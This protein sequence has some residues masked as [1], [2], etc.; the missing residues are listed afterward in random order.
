[1]AFLEWD[2]QYVNVHR[3]QFPNISPSHPPTLP[4][5]RGKSKYLET[6]VVFFRC[7][8][9]IVP[10][11][12]H[13]CIFSPIGHELV[14]KRISLN[15]LPR[16]VPWCKENMVTETS[17]KSEPWRCWNAL[18]KTMKFTEHKDWLAGTP[19]TRKNQRVFAVNYVWWVPKLHFT[20]LGNVI[21]S[22]FEEWSKSQFMEY[23]LCVGHS[24]SL[25]CCRW[26]IV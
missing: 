4:V 23:Q 12:L 19:E 7:S 20:C 14:R 18:H 22:T 13:P 16:K 25:N 5:T 21:F 1:M 26:L 11:S 6:R 10:S 17:K 8:N 24:I 15:H 2:L 3:W 9:D